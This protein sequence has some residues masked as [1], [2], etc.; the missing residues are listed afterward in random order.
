MESTL[1]ADE[2]DSSAV[3][4]CSGGFYVSLTRVGNLLACL[5]KVDKLLENFSLDIDIC[6]QLTLIAYALDVLQI[7]ARQLFGEPLCTS[8]TDAHI[9]QLLEDWICEALSQVRVKAVLDGV[10]RA[11]MNVLCNITPPIAVL[12]VQ[13]DDQEVLL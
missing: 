5:A 7:L 12:A 6:R 1:F 8:E 3:F 2:L 13:L 9:Q 11:A 4:A 10:V